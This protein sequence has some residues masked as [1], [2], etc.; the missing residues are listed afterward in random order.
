MACDSVRLVTGNDFMEVADRVVCVD[1]EWKQITKLRKNGI[2]VELFG[3]NHAGLG[4][5]PYKTLATIVDLDGIRLVHMADEIL[6]S[7][8]ENYRAVNF[9][10]DG[11]DIAFADIMFL[12]DSTGQHIMKEYIKPQYII[13]MHSGPS[14]LDDAAR[15]LRP[16]YP[17]FIIYWD[18]LEKKVFGY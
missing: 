14:E 11:I 2:G 7:N 18:Q 17:N 3:V 16:L 9:A 12:A 4:Q 8:V 10:R 13:L 6:E 15:R 1:P 5:E